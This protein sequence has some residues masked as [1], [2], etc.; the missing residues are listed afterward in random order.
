MNEK[1]VGTIHDM[2]EI[3]GYVNNNK[4]KEEKIE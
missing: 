3:E 4:N 1:N 2:I